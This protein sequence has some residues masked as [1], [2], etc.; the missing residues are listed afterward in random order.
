MNPSTY[1]FVTKSLRRLNRTRVLRSNAKA[2]CTI[3]GLQTIRDLYPN[4]EVL[5][6]CG[7]RRTCHNRKPEDVEAY[8]IAS[9]E[10]EARKQIVGKNHVNANGYVVT[11]VEDLEAA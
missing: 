4:H 3:H 7:C 10:Q 5:L 8:D 1:Q 2:Y 6:A 9:R 11:Y